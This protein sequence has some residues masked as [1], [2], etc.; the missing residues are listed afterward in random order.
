MAQEARNTEIVNPY[1][2]GAPVTGTEMFF[3][4]EDVFAFIRQALTGR[5]RD[6]VIVLYG[7]RR[8]G[9]TSVLYQMHRHLDARYLCIFIDLHGL[10]LEGLDGFLWELANNMAR[11]LRREYQ[12]DPPR[13]N[14]A[15]FIVDARS[16]FENEFL[17][18]VWAAIGNR[19][20][21]LMLDE[22]I[23]LQEQIQAGKLEKDVFEYLRHL[24]QH[25][26]R[27]NFLFSLGSGLEEMEKEY[28]FLFSVGLYKKISF[29]DRDAATALIT[30]P[31]QDYYQVDPSAIE[32]IQVMTSG[33]AYYTQLICHSL[34]N[35]WQQQRQPRVQASDVDAVLNEVVERGLAVLKHVWEESTPAEKAVLAGMAAVMGDR[36][37]PIGPQEINRT[38]QRLNVALPENERAKAIKSLIA[39]DVIIGRD[40]YEFAVELQRLWVQKYE[41][42]EWV[43]EEIAA[44]LQ[45]WRTES[46]TTVARQAFWRSKTGLLAA[47]A[48]VALVFGIVAWIA[49]GAASRQTQQA[50]EARATAEG[51][52][53]TAEGAKATG[54]NN[55]NT[56]PTGAAANVSA[57]AIVDNIIWAA[58][59]GGLVRWI[60]DG[61]GRAFDIRDFNFPGNEPGSIVAAP[62]GTLWIG[63]GGVA[64]VRPEDDRLQ[65]LGYYNKD[66]GLGT[67]V[68]RTLMIDT[69]G[70]IW[71]GGPK[72]TES[73]LSHF[74]ADSMTW[75]TDEIPMDSPALQ[76]VALNIQSL[77]RSRDGAL[78]LGLRGDGILRWDGKEWTHFGE[79]QGVGR[80]DD[81][82][83]R[84]RQLLQDRKGTIWAAAS[85]QGLLRFDPAQ[86]RWQRIAVVHDNAPIRTITEFA[87][88]ELWAAGD[89]LVARS[90]DGGQTW[91]QVGSAS[92]GIG[93]NIGAIVQDAAG[94]VWIGAYD[95]GI[96]Y[97]DDG[98][99]RQLQ[100]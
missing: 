15:Q 4:R 98:R 55:G 1:I 78:W 48:V 75:R 12:L 71:A 3:G 91:T 65:Y 46:G 33:H 17:N 85:D 53:A 63:A 31:V 37:R 100:R 42:L 62:D 34:F 99:W 95:G 54:D 26:E 90:T 76:G 6:N 86:G 52:R 92:D 61:T 73:P 28:A 30:Q 60:S 89:E 74:T 87:D 70:S 88:G 27:L 58:T 24:M 67:G 56:N 69:D 25:H 19:H 35:R 80:S 83:R 29:L 97:Y 22:A 13:L 38:W 57:L 50:E 40:Q 84:I 23:R 2:A 79:A 51:F 77:L 64:Q 5:H 68:V 94:R 18:W 49:F 32:R 36:N 20:I 16:T 21:L 41:R 43:K 11:T 72:Q 47:L 44:D 45:R 93:I 9:K 59:D 66:D 96:S 82:E 14:R 81:A 8:T 39:R 10:A 7:Q